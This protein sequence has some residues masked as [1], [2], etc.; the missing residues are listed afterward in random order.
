MRGENRG[1][2]REEMKKGRGKRGIDR[3]GKMCGV[4]IT[5]NEGDGKDGDT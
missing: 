4:E 2:G 1:G 5:K 3:K